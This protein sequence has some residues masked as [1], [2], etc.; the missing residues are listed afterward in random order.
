MTEAGLQFHG[1]FDGPSIYST[2]T[3]QGIQPLVL[4]IGVWMKIIFL[5]PPIYF[6]ILMKNIVSDASLKNK[7]Q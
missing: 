5:S 1:W 3:L 2:Y 7:P 4:K 6:N